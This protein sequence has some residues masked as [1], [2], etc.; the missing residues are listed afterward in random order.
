MLI[1]PVPLTTYR[2]VTFDELSTTE[3]G[4]GGFGSSG[5]F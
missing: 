5:R 1:A 2:E 4:Q 3:R